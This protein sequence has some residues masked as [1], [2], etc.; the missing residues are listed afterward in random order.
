[1][2]TTIAVVFWSIL[3]ATI[4]VDCVSS[5]KATADNTGR[6]L[7]RQIDSEVLNLT[8]EKAGKI[9]F[10]YSH[11]DGAN[12]AEPEFVNNGMSP[13]IALDY[14]NNPWV[15]YRQND[16]IFCAIRNSNS[17]WKS[18]VLFGGTS[19][20]K[21]GPTSMAISS[22]HPNSGMPV[23]YAVFPVY[24]LGGNQSSVRCVKFDSSKV[25]A[26]D[27]DKV[28]GMIDS[29]A[30][31]AL[32]SCDILHVCW[33]QA[34]DIFYSEAE[35]T[36]D[37]WEEVEW[38]EPFNVSNICNE[39]ARHPFIESF[40]DSIYV[41]FV[42]DNAK[43]LIAAR[44]ISD[45]NDSWIY[46]IPIQSNR[47]KDYP[48]MRTNELIAWQEL[49]D[50]N[51][52]EIYANIQGDTANVSLTSKASE[53]C[54]IEVGYPDG[55]GEPEGP[56]LLFWSEER[57]HGNEYEVSFCK[58]E[59]ETSDN[60]G[61]QSRGVT[62]TNIE[63]ILYQNTPNPFGSVTTISY[64][65]PIESRVVLILY[66][67]AGKLVRTFK[68]ENQKPGIYQ[69]QWDGSGNDRKPLANGT[70]FYELTTSNCQIVKK[71]V[72]KR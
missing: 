1:M 54:H 22:I 52:W 68:A 71:M 64:N 69:Y 60:G 38:T 25:I 9:M 49:V 62:K 56:P 53:Y 51:N 45:S 48:V 50:A 3:S 57:E 42:E 24:D 30:S 2:F 41:T 65:L 67:A 8:Y 47:P 19:N 70:Y 17:S 61:P 36:P 10:T 26:G 14:D 35:V 28:S 27:I 18:I 31:I 23:G 6:K 32:T 44:L 11:D 43:I 58:Y 72:I 16:T 15:S 46:R 21:P 29:S 7:V 12:W 39:S 20:S 55:Q 33:Q 37:D 66:D 40:E 13:C 5:I 4:S 63:P 34:D 59:S